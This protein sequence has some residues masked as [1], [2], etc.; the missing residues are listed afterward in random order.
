ML[1]LPKIAQ[2]TPQGR[3]FEATGLRADS[4]RGCV[5]FNRAY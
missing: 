4:A 3:V 2:T 5:A 1:A